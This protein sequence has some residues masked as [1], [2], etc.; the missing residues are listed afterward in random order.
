MN[1]VTGG[2]LTAALGVAIIAAW[3]GGAFG[4]LIGD[5]TG[6]VRGQSSSSA[7]STS[8]AAAAPLPPTSKSLVA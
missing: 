7:T 6:L 4:Q 3:M 5:V 2:F 8:T 1:R